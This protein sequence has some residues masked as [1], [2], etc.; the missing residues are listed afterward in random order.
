MIAILTVMLAEFQDETSAEL[1]AATA[2]RATLLV[3]GDLFDSYVSRAQVRHGVWREVAGLFAHA[4]AAGVPVAMLV[5]NRDF[6]LD[7]PVPGF[8]GGAFSQ[9]CGAI[10]LSDPFALSLHGQAAL[11]TGD[12]A[13]LHD[14]HGWLWQ[15]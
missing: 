12:L 10:L 1:A 11:L 14:S 8:E 5:G 15:R 6:L 13:L 2:Q 9:R 4:V 3:L 7:V